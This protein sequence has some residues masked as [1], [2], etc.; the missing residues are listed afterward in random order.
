M[1]PQQL[2]VREEGPN[3]LVTGLDLI[4]LDSPRSPHKT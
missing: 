3:Y 2:E 1:S 4:G